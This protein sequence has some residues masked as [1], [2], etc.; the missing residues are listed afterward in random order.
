MYQ[1]RS[2]PCP[3]PQH[4]LLDHLHVH[5]SEYP[6]QGHRPSRSWQWVRRREAYPCLL[7]VGAFHAVLPSK[8]FF[9]IKL[10]FIK[11]C[12]FFVLNR[13]L[14]TPLLITKNCDFYILDRE[15]SVMRYVKYDVIFQ[16][17]SKSDDL[18]PYKFLLLETNRFKVQA[19][20]F[21]SN[22]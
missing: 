17:V 6:D 12:D 8:Y 11:N 21:Y 19:C 14:R 2:G 22:A 20:I 3:R 13:G 10:L 5:T 7:S 15:V 16:R 18:P 4:L 9:I 1:R